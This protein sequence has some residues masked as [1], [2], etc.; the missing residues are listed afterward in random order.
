MS[1]NSRLPEVRTSLAYAKLLCDFDWEGAEKEFRQAILFENRY[2]S[3]HH[4]YANLLVMQGRFSE[5]EDEMDRALHLDSGSIVIRKTMGDPYYYSRRYEKAIDR[6][7]AALKTEMAH[8]FLGW[9]YQQVGET[10]RALQEFEAVSAC[11]GVSSIVQG[12]IG[13]LYATSGQESKALAILDHLREQ[14]GASYVAPHTLAAI[15]AGLGDKDQAFEW[16]DASYE[17]RIELLAW[18]K[19]DPRF[20][21]L[22]GDYRFDRFLEKI[23]LNP[24]RGI[25][26]S[27]I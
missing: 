8:L 6:Y 11:K 22:R 7:S 17:N 12:A 1:L 13:H 2:P 27:Q 18:I 5:A 9:A 24:P 16:L 15:F 4:W 21:V 26:A 14:I 10:G 19:V 23:G 20:E 25:A 3:A